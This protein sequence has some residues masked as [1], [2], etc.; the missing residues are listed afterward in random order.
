VTGLSPSDFERSGRVVFLSKRSGLST[1][2]TCPD[3][4]EFLVTRA[5]ARGAG[6]K[7][8]LKVFLKVKDNQVPL[9][10]KLPSR[11]APDKEADLV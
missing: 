1:I 7:L 5:R 4:F 6:P 10:L 2:G 9:R 11:W 3:R 8:V